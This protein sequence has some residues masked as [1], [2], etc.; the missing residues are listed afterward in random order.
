MEQAGGFRGSFSGYERDH[1]FYRPDGAGEPFVQSGYVFGL[2]A[3]HDGRAAAPVDID[4]DGDLDLAL[5]TL[6]GL[7]LFENTSAPRRFAR[8][9][10][11]ATRSRRDA[12]G[13]EVVLTAGGQRRRDFVKITEGF[14]AQV[15]LDLHFGLGES[16]T[17]D[18]LE[19][20][21]PSGAV[22]VWNDLP[23]DR[24]LHVREG[25]ADVA[26][27][28]LERWSDGTRPRLTAAPSP[29][30]VAQRLDGEPAPVGGGRPA[31]LNFWAPWCAPCNEELPQLVELAGRY[32]N[33]VD[34]VGL[35]VELRDLDSVRAS[36]A[37]FAIPY[38]QFLADEQVMA[39][40][41]GTEDEA[42][43]PS[44]FVFDGEGRLRR[45]FRGAVTEPVLDA[46]LASFRDEAVNEVA[47]RLLAETHM[48][49][50]EYAQAIDYYTRLA[51]LEPRRLYQIRQAWRRQ[52]ARDRF[53]AGRAR[54]L[55]GQAGEAIGDFGAALAV[56]GEDDEVLVQLGTAEAVSGLLGLAARTFDRAIA[57]EPESV[58]ARI[59][60]AR[61]HVAQGE[62]EAARASYEQALRLEPG[63]V[64]ARRELAHLNGP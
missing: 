55:A 1:L 15:P 22:E 37:R 58:R 62:R 51:E 29:S 33:E 3:D 39:Q 13:A 52:R 50:G 34:F 19:V 35:S 61:V 59:G 23:V 18:A 48:A 11:T 53:Q 54:L 5:L 31:V 42:A 38:S 17:V 6:R 20:R 56:L 47:L 4:G 64:D 57:A 8:V 45:L 30:V 60:R 26:A 49:G 14:R 10:L 7:R 9:R 27:E 25:A 16:T 63:N 40:F 43:L 28:A 36:I 21:W 12:L 2:D 24:L 41:F 32:A 46:L 44:T